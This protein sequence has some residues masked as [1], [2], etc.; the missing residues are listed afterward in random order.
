[1]LATVSLKRVSSTRLRTPRRRIGADGQR[2]L[3]REAAIAAFAEAGIDG[4][5]VEDVISRAAVS[6]QTFYR[7][8]RSK[9]E[10]LDDVHRLITDRLV[11]VMAQMRD[12]DLSPGE[13]LV[14]HLSR[15]FDHAAR[16]GPIVC[17][18]GRQALRP[19]SSFFEHRRQRYAF[20]ARFI[21][22]WV[23]ARFDARPSEP[24]TEA[25]VYGIEQL[26]FEVAQIG[27]RP[28]SV[29]MARERAAVELVEAL[30]LHSGVDRA[31]FSVD[32]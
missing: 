32:S 28:R 26:W 19:D 6:R 18:L 15:L 29:R 2:E 5:S 17:E 21:A 14:S 31:A 9:A 4:T 7:C 16:S 3:L 23:E 11:A 10:L 12:D 24:L 22:R 20:A 1:M 13:A 27:G 8:Y 25:V 30:L